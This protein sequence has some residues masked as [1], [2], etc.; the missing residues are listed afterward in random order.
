MAKKIFFTALFGLATFILGMYSLATVHS[1]KPIEPHQ[2]IFTSM[3][4]IGSLIY[5]LDKEK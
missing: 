2:W 5:A 4:A 3:L 1:I